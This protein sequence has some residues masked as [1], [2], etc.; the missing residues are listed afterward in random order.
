MAEKIPTKEEL[1]KIY[2]AMKRDHPEKLKEIEEMYDDI[3]SE[4]M[5]KPTETEMYIRNTFAQK[6]YPKGYKNVLCNECGR[7]LIASPIIRRME[8]LQ[9]NTKFK[10]RHYYEMVLNL[11]YGQ[12]ECPHCGSP[13]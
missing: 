12:P 1:D 9:K 7:I 8:M 2:E 3:G 4:E 5:E 6:P 11:A 13:Q 10:E